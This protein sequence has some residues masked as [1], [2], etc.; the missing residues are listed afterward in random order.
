MLQGAPL[1]AWEYQGPRQG[2]QALVLPRAGRVWVLLGPALAS[3]NTW[4]AR[5]GTMAD[6]MALGRTLTL[7]RSAG[8]TEELF[9]G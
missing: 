4:M 5:S 2:L 8:C 6:M 1:V 7:V 9:C 3:T